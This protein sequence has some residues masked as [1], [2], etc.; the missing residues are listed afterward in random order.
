MLVLNTC[1]PRNGEKAEGSGDVWT[2]LEVRKEFEGDLN[3]LKSPAVAAAAA[4]VATCC[5]C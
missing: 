4:K 3:W 5:C 1:P 2:L